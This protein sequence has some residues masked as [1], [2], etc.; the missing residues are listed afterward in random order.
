MQL[1]GRLT[2]R[3]TCRVGYLYSDG[4]CDVV[5]FSLYSDGECDVVRLSLYCVCKYNSWL[6]VLGFMVCINWS[7]I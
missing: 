7:M 2:G 4:E 6:I 5:R 1:A 3:V